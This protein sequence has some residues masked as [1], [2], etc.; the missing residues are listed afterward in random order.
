M[1]FEEYPSA[2]GARVVQ[3][4][5]ASFGHTW[6]N[7]DTTNIALFVSKWIMKLQFKK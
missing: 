4:Y 6:R 3:S 7:Y 2:K 1:G 5:I